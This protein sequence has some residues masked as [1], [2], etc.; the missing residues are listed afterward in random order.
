M[1]VNSSQATLELHLMRRKLEGGT[2]EYMFAGQWVPWYVVEEWIESKGLTPGEIW[3]YHDGDDLPPEFPAELKTMLEGSMQK[4]GKSVVWGSNEMKK[5]IHRRRAVL[6]TIS[7]I[8][9]AAMLTAAFTHAWP[10][11]M[12]LAGFLGYNT[13]AIR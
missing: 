11:A 7:A 10:A 6:L 12:G 3:E 8:L 13:R 1:T 5:R 2:I 9:F 4:A